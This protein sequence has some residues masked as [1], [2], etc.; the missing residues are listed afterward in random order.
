MAQA[1]TLEQAISALGEARQEL[2]DQADP[3]ELAQRTA[4]AGLEQRLQQNPLAEGA[5]AAEQ[6]RNL[7]ASL[8]NAQP[9]GDG[10]CR[11]RTGGAGRRPGR[12]RP[13]A[14]RC[15]RR[16]GRRPCGSGGGSRGR[17]PRPQTLCV[18]RAADQLDASNE[19]APPRPP[20]AEAQAEVRDAQAA[21]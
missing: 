5:T 4:L 12:D 7:A 9:G 11:R 16:R 3:A 14:V 10:R 13:G 17:R 15:P 1:E 6:L 2:A 19:A 20:R 21:A 18:E 8:A